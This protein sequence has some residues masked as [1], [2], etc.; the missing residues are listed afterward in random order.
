MPQPAPSQ[1]RKL[2]TNT[3]WLYSLQGLNYVLPMLMLPYLVRVLGVGNYGLIAVAQAFAQYF[4][5]F[6]DYG[7]NLSATKRIAIANGEDAHAIRR[8]FWGVLLVKCALL[9]AGFVLLLGITSVIPA[10]ASMRTAY[11][12]AYLAVL[13]NVLFPVWYFQGIEKMKIISIITGLS[14]IVTVG[15]I[16]FLVRGPADTVRALALQS[17]A[18]LLAGI[19]GFAVAARSNWKGGAFPRSAD[20]VLLLKEG[21]HLFLSTA[22][23]TLYTNTNVF[24]VGQIGGVAQAGYFSAAEK[25]IRAAQGLLIPLTQVLFPHVNTLMKQSR[26]LAVRF[27]RKS[28]LTIALP[29]FAGSLVILVCAPLLAHFAF[30]FANNSTDNTLR[31][32]SFI[33]FLIAVS[34]ILGIQTM[35]VFGHEKAFSR[36]LI[37]A[38][39]FN[40]ALAWPLIHRMGAPGAGAAVLATEAFITLTML[41]YLPRIGIHLLRRDPDAKVTANVVN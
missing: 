1:R 20:L 17:S 6:T 13:G 8:T 37:T 32:I 40:I 36:I 22:A 12:V 19:F 4:T 23:V 9:L 33:P 7:F 3:L 31:W 14:R 2:L 21:W 38:G 25:I 35:V 30:G 26:Q 16:F 28:L 11:L 18:P 41:L 5:I 10:M 15:S 27:I 29:T 34:N 24:L 39:C